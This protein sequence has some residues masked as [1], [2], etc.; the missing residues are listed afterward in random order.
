MEV[1]E[2]VSDQTRAADSIPPFQLSRFMGHANVTTTLT[3]YAHLINTDDHAGN[4]A[5]LGALA[6]LGGNGDL[7]RQRDPATGL[8]LFAGQFQ[9]FKAP[10]KEAG[11]PA[12]S[13]SGFDFRSVFK[14]PTDH[15]LGFQPGERGS[16]A[17]VRS[18]AEGDVT[19]PVAA[20]QSE[21]VGIVEVRWIPI[22][23][24]PQQQQARTRFKVYTAQCGV[25]YDVTVMA[26]ERRFVAQYLLKECAEQFRLVAHLLLNIGASRQNPCCGTD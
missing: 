4:M 2:A 15:D 16:D 21:L 7:R 3:V 23:R 8:E 6:S 22:R 10:Y 24:S 14:E 18:L 19:L 5:A 20:V 17:E 26:P 1:I 13:V 12:P 11:Q 25:A 9:A